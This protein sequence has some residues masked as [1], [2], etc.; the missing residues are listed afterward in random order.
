MGANV[1]IIIIGWHGQAIIILQGPPLL[2]VSGKTLPAACLISRL[3]TLV[4]WW[5][6]HREDQTFL[7]IR[8]E[9]RTLS[10]K[11]EK[12]SMPLKH[13]KSARTYFHCTVWLWS[14]FTIISCALCQDSFH[15]I[16]SY[17][18]KNEKNPEKTALQWQ[19]IKNNG[20]TKSV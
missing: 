12:R 8:R 7:F 1:I 4:P 15:V 5:W 16:Y 10:S 3:D 20:H 19:Y 6:M 13:L 18:S 11:E 17:I 2:E 9:I 14:P